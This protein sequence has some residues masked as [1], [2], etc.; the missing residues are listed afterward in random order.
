MW[1]DEVADRRP[2]QVVAPC[3]EQAPGKHKLKA[4]LGNAAEEQ[5]TQDVQDAGPGRQVGAPAYDAQRTEMGTQAA[6]NRQPSHIWSLLR[7]GWAK[8]GR[9]IGVLSVWVFVERLTARLHRIRPVQPKA[10]LRYALERHR[11]EPVVLRDGTAIANGD[12]IIELHFDNRRLVELTRAGTN[13]WP[14]LQQARGDLAALDKLL[15]SGAL[16]E[17]KALHGLTLFAPAGARVG[18]E[19]RPLPRTWRFALDRFFMAG[20]VM[21]YNPSGWRA[22]AHQAAR[23]P[24]EVWMSRA[25]LTHRYGVEGASSSPRT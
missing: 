16:G 1:L 19:A 8:G 23:W 3:P 25:T 7:L 21:L 14:L 11:G 13:P 12:P 5:A 18:F 24:G 22:A 15:S 10:M 17:V 2:V 6:R 9:A 20:L 4:R